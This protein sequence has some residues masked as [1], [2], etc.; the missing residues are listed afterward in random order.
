[1]ARAAVIGA[2]ASSAGVALTATAG[3]LIARAAEHPP[4]LMLMVAI[5]GVRLF[6]LAR[7]AL[8][9]AERLIA[10]D[11]ALA[12]LADRRADVFDVLVPLTPARL[13]RQR[14]DLLTSV[15]DDVDSLLDKQLRVRMPLVAAA[16]VGCLASG[17]ATW[18]FPAAGLATLLVMVV[19]G[20]GAWLAART[21]VRRAEPTHVKQRAALSA[22]IAQTLQGAGELV[23]WQ[24]VQRRLDAVDTLGIAVG[25]AMS[26][27]ARAV[28]TGRALATCVTGAGMLGVAWVG[29]SEVV[30][31]T[32]S[33]PMLAL[34]V[35][36]PLALADVLTP[37][38]DAGAISVRTQAADARLAQL[39]DVIPAVTSPA[40]PAAVDLA[41]PTVAADR[42]SAGWG[43]HDAFREVSLDLR[44]GARIG[45]VGPSGSG[46]S[47][48]AALMLR[49][50]D[51]TAGSI[52]LAGAPMS[53]LRLSDVRRTVGLVDDD[54]YV[55]GSTLRE[56]LTLAA[57]Q[58]TDE[59]LLS[60][61]DA[62]ALG[63]WVSSLGKGLDTR[64]GDGADDVSGG[65]RARI[66]MARALLANSPVLVLDEPTA[67]LDRATAEAVTGDL[68]S[69][70]G[71]TLM[72]ITHGTVG[73]D[74]MDA[75]LTL[76]RAHDSVT[77]FRPTTMASGDGDGCVGHPARGMNVHL[78]PHQQ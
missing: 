5:V 8:R 36:L 67:H 62:V 44:P 3:W 54:P 2:L 49:F 22:L 73:L 41:S 63:P 42:V 68:L 43:D 64:L 34:L 17:F 56:N 15:V 37:L 74:Q 14:G 69:T 18:Q 33:K 52:A 70:Q 40:I 45:V 35:L 75:V 39:A 32:L 4:V 50:L 51:P 12:V 58:A 38:A 13:P 25:D 55:F 61:L 1:M 66:G 60:A 26:R 28:A 29:S 59:D 77:S 19:G 10:H 46:K 57:P 78:A 53:R 31:G 21:G 48:L 6:G 20:G 47:T 16:L 65:E 71:R 7:P 76:G 27:S 11:T 24:G 30:A 23:M 9:Y 72:W